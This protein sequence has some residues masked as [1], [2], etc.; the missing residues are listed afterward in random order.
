M[1]FNLN[2]TFKNFLGAFI[3][4]LLPLLII[5]ISMVINLAEMLSESDISIALLYILFIT[6][7]AV[8]L[9]FYGAIYQKTKTI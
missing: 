2:I 6:W 4:F 5:I 9:I 1:E 8:G 3:L 7:F